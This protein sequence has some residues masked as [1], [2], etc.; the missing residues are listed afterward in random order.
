[1]ALLEVV[2]SGQEHVV[3]LRHELDK[4][5][6]ALDRTDAVLAIADETLTRAEEAIVQTRRWAPVLVGGVGLVAVGVAAAI[7]IRRR[8]QAASQG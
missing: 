5:R 4:V 7:I 6:V 2:E 1:M 3:D 8:Q